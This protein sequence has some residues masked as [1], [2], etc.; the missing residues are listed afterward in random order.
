[1]ERLAQPAAGLSW[2]RRIQDTRYGTARALRNWYCV[3]SSRTTAVRSTE[4][5]LPA[6]CLDLAS[7]LPLLL[8]LPLACITHSCRLLP[9]AGRVLGW[10]RDGRTGP[11]IQGG[12]DWSRAVEWL[13]CLLKF[14]CVG[15]GTDGGTSKGLGC[16]AH[17]RADDG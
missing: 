13:R 4:H 15:W 16:Y 5:V 6:P 1:M 11:S 14:R 10:S 8:T 12:H 7:A 3:P 9:F 2:L 17:A